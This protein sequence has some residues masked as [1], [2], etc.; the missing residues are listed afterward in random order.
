VIV[1]VNDLDITG[2]DQATEFFKALT[3]EGEVTILLQRRLSTH[4]LRLKII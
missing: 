3:Q 1:G 2:P 4:R